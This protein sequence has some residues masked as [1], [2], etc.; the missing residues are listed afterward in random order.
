MIDTISPA[1][2][3]QYHGHALFYKI[4]DE[5]KT[6]HSEKNSVYASAEEPLANFERTGQLISKFLK[7][8]INPK[9]ASCLSLMSKQIDGIYEMVGAGKTGKFESLEDKLKDTAVYSII[10]MIILRELKEKS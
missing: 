3:Q 4:I 10:A 6:L 5:L 2:N 7:P 1:D 9:L 8:G